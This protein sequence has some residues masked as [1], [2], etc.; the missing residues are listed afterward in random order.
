MTF[1]AGGGQW[2]AVLAGFA[3]HDP[4]DE[5]I[6]KPFHSQTNTEGSI[7]IFKT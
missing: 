5:M 7:C 3:K 6:G 1:L 2:A 4:Y